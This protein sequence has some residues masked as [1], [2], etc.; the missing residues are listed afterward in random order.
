MKKIYI[1][2]NAEIECCFA[3]VMQL[4]LTSIGQSGKVTEPDQTVTNWDFDGDGTRTDD[5]DAK[6]SS[7][8]DD[9]SA[10][11]EEEE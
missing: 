4:P 2:P 3:E 7:I 10:E 8:W 6:A 9:W 5:P 11:G 1:A